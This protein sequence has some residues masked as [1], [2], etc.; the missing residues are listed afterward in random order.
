MIM[1]VGMLE[2]G[3]SADMVI[4]VEGDKIVLEVIL[5]HRTS[6]IEA[7]RALKQRTRCLGNRL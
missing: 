4:S 3:G 6:N 1:W 5:R 7:V 2:S